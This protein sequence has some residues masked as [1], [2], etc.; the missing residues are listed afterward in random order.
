[1]KKILITGASGFIGSHTVDEALKRG[2]EVV[3]FDRRQNPDERVTQFLGDITDYHAVR[4]AVNH[5]DYAIN[6]A[7]IL[8]TQETINDPIPSIE[9]NTIGAI[10]FFKACIPTKF[11]KVKAVQIGVGNYWMSN[12]YSI[13]KSSAVRFAYMYN[14]E[15]NTKIAVVRALNAYGERQKSEPVRKVIPTF[16]KMA[17]NNQDIEIYGNGEQIM[18]MIYVKD[19]AKILVDACIKDHNIYDKAMDAGTGR[20]TTV[21]WIA[22]QVIKESK[23]KSKIKHIPMRPGEPEGSIVVAEPKTLELLGD[24]K[25]TSFED[26]IKKTVKWYSDNLAS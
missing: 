22:E 6:L 4:E 11:H 25:L 16:V 17:L 12:S 13:S 19:L 14:K 7:G 15:H 1:M 23:S 5:V 9:V 24:Y 2:L 10:N 8:G 18:D 26:G 20:K 21:N 3:A